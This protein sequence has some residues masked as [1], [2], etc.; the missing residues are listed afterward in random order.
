MTSKSDNLS[1]IYS[2]TGPENIR[3]VCIIAHVDHGKTSLA[4][5]LI[6]SNGIISSRMAGK[7]RYMDSREDE[8]TRGITMKTS[9]ISLFYKPIVI[10]LVDSP[11]HVDFA[12]EVSNAINVA[13]ISILVVDVVEGV[14]SQTETVLRQAIK[15]RHDVILVI[16]K[17]DRLI[18]ELGF[19]TSQAYKHI[20]M[21][22]EQVNSCVSQI[23]QG[24]LIDEKWEDIEK[25]EEKIQFDPI[26]GNVIFASATHGFG[27]GLEDF[28]VLWADKL[29]ISKD[30]LKVYLFSDVYLGAGMKILRDAELKGK[31]TIFEKLVLDPMWE[32]Y[33]CSFEHKDIERLK[34]ISNKMNITVKSK[35]INEAFDEFMKQWMPLTKACVRSVYRCNSTKTCFKNEDR[36]KSLLQTNDHPLMEYVRNADENSNYTILI[37]AKVFKYGDKKVGMCRVLSGKVTDGQKLYFLNDKHH[38]K[39]DSEC[40]KEVE[41]DITNVNVEEVFMMMGRELAPV[42]FACTGQICGITIDDNFKGTTLCSEFIKNGEIALNVSSVE[43]LVH[44]SIMPSVSGNDE[45]EELK[46]ALKLLTIFDSSVRVFEADSGEL[47]LVTA[48]EVHLQ[49]C[50]E[51]LK[52]LGQ[53]NIIVSAPV[54]P[55]L[56]TIIP[57]TN[58][59]YTKIVFNQITECNIKSGLVNIKLRAIPLPIDIC[60]FIQK[61]KSILKRIREKKIEKE[62]KKLI[63]FYQNFKEV[64]EKCLPGYK[65]TW[66]Y[67]KSKEDVLKII[68]NIWCFGPPKA[69]CNILINNI[70]DESKETN[71]VFNVSKSRVRW[72]DRAFTGGFDLAMSGGP[73]AEEPLQGVAIVVE[74]FSMGDELDSTMQGQLISAIKNTIRASLKKHPLRLVSAMYRCLIQASPSV[75]G[76]VHTVISQRRAKTIN[77]DVN[78][79]NGLFEIEAFMPVVESFA[80]CEDLR[81]KSSGMASATLEFSHWQ[82]VDEDPFW[83]PTTEDEKEHFGEKGDSVNQAKVYMDNIRRRKG[84][85]TDDLIVVNAEKQRNLSRNK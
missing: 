39:N 34:D 56:E 44:V 36:L 6:S 20:R 59:S 47:N 65:G 37:V 21:L 77:E 81:K 49:K 43:P 27:F 78:Q 76:K 53:K 58:L 54:V 60:T 11:G 7:L 14:C 71:N 23:L 19:D 50:L 67:K 33:K 83:I 40:E 74:E 55:F 48:G 30:E 24:Y 4:D 75:L 79:T 25:E 66:W 52:D 42:P 32:V 22:I 46:E 61:N 63:E 2:N 15:C 28:A 64:A 68:D 17:F 35:R 38:R 57:E 16:N 72:I 69:K 9:T 1:D 45:F 8:Q 82:I 18:C 51:D 10:N 29:N 41:L 5:T 73:L 26:K 13:D 85:L 80:F 12:S 31:K 3:N 84:L 70:N 62:D